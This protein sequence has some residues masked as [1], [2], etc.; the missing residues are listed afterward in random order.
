MMKIIFILLL[1]FVYNFYD[2]GFP[3]FIHFFGKKSK[4]EFIIIQNNY[5][6]FYAYTYKVNIDNITKIEEVRF[7]ERIR[8]F[9]M[10]ANKLKIYCLKENVILDCNGRNKSVS[11]AYYDTEFY[12]TFTAKAYSHNN[13]LILTQSTNTSVFVWGNSLVDDFQLNLIKAPYNEIY[14][15]IQ[16]EKEI[17]YETPFVLIGLKDCFIVIKKVSYKEY[18]EITY[19]IVDFDLNIINSF[20]VQYKDIKYIDFFQI[21]ENNLVNEFIKCIKYNF[22][23][24]CQVIKYENKNLKFLKSFDVFSYKGSYYIYELKY[25][26]FDENKIGFLFYDTNADNKY[27]FISIFQYENQIL[28]IYKN[29][30]NVSIPSLKFLYDYGKVFFAITEQ[31]IGIFSHYLY[32][33]FSYLSPICLS[34]TIVLYA[35]ELSEFPIEEFIIPGVEP[36]QFS[37]EEIYEN[38]IIYKDSSEIKIGEVFYDLNNFTYLLK[39]E[40]FFREIKIKV[41]NH[42]FDYICEIDV[43]PYTNTNISTY[44]DQ[45]K[46]FRNNDY[47]EINNIVKS[48]L[49]DYFT[50]DDKIRNIKIELTMEREPKGPELIFYWDDHRLICTKNSK[51]IICNIFVN[52]FPR[53][54][55][56]HLYSYL[57]CYN[58]VDV[59]WFELNDK[60]IFN[61]Y[62][63]IYDDFDTI[64]KIYDPSTNISEYNPAMINY[65]YWFICLSYCSEIKI[66]RRECCENILDKWE[67]VFNKEYH[68]KKSFVDTIFDILEKIRGA[69]S[70]KEEFDNA[71][72]NNIGHLDVNSSDIQLSDT[73][74]IFIE[75]IVTAAAAKIT[76]MINEQFLLDLSTPSFLEIEKYATLDFNVTELLHF[77]R[78]KM[79]KIIKT[80]DIKKVLYQFLYQYN[81]VILKND[82]YKKIVVAF[83]GSSTFFE[84][85]DEFIFQGKVELDIE[86]ED[87]YIDVMENYYDIFNLIKED[88]FNN[89][90]SITG[91]NDPDYQV[92]FVGHSIGGAIATISSFYYIKEYNFNATNILITFGQPKVGNENF[93]K[94][95]TNLMDGRIYRIARPDDVAT[96]FPLTGIDFFFKTLK[97]IMIGVDFAIY[98][99]KF[100]LHPDLEDLLND[101]IDIIKDG[102]D[103]LD[104]INDYL[105]VYSLSDMVYSHIGGLYMIDENTNTV[106]QCDDF[107][108]EKRDHFICKN[109]DFKLT[110][111]TLFGFFKNRNYLTKEKKS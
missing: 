43:D 63:L 64:S 83:P 55:R 23:F 61:I 99:V 50:V 84:L 41:K 40:T 74:N 13:L 18:E 85:I 75:K 54:T 51:K 37:F 108:N 7:N 97:K 102:G 105:Q 1:A 82:E 56:I 69:V 36:L 26:N 70:L 79:H 46:C 39:I 78:S 14:K 77:N 10:I 12:K 96:K 93:A 20:S 65:Y 31:G 34:K 88:L 100:A 94:L 17:F 107:Y 80:I 106:Y 35:N 15:S 29:Y 3:S 91:I 103:T 28:S 49:Y 16:I 53:L 5:I 67:V 66:N 109:H 32:A 6:D 19:K 45:Q 22:N 104:T 27:D 58:L 90:A 21:S 4:N 47:E 68:Y 9:Q 11:W 95:F 62:S 86:V 72:V 33:H 76:D 87:I 111:S 52:L 42:E 110:L 25:H 48:N 73:L 98:W 57:S 38:L 30:R 81:F 8:D 2:M 92:I 59:G 71:N 60:N 44:K 24:E 101:I 89:L